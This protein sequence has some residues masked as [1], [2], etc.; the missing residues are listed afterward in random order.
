[1]ALVLAGCAAPSAT[2][3]SIHDGERSPA[4]IDGSEATRLLKAR[5]REGSQSQVPTRLDQPLNARQIVLPTYPR[6]K[7]LQA[8]EG[9]VL[10]DFTIGTDG[11]VGATRVVSSP[12]NVLSE[13]ALQAVGQWV[14][15]PPT[16][17]GSP[18]TYPVRIPLEFRLR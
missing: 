9:T 17:D 2:L 10:V 12:D 18:R 8:V 4:V 1:M 5:I 11:K 14:F 13:A 7:L 15:D 16:K 3:Y 6:E